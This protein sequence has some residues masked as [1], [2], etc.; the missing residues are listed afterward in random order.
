MS[1][2][3]ASHDAVMT[4]RGKPHGCD[5]ATLSAV[6]V[7]SKLA[8]RNPDLKVGGEGLGSSSKDAFFRVPRRSDDLSNDHLRHI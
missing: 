2:G 5:A 4:N 8:R 7:S 1:G 6:R 3:E